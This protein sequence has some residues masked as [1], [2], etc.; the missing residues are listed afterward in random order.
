MPRGEFDCQRILSHG[1]RGRPHPF[2]KHRLRTRS[3]LPHRLIS[4]P[5]RDPA[6]R[7]LV[8]TAQVLHSRWSRPTGNLLGLGEI[9]TF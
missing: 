6:D 5:H 9:S 2:A 4:L 8:A 1:W 3:R 7:F